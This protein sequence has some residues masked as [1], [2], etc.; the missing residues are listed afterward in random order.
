M[1]NWRLGKELAS[2]QESSQNE[3]TSVDKTLITYTLLLVVVGFLQFLVLAATVVILYFQTRLTEHSL[4]QWVEIGN[5][6]VEKD[7]EKDHD[8]H[9]VTCT[10]E[11]FNRTERPLT[12]KRVVT[13]VAPM[14]KGARRETYQ[15][16]ENLMLAPHA[17]SGYTCKAPINLGKEEFAQFLASNLFVFFSGQVFIQSIRGEKPLSGFSN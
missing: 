8:I 3:D 15:V 5:W 13:E 2:N 9:T 16:T 17:S 6:T 14:V 1:T 10:F 11:L 12:L 4:Q 7:V